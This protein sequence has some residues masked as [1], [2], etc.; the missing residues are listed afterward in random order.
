MAGVTILGV[1]FQRSIE[2]RAGPCDLSAI[3]VNQAQVIMHVVQIWVNLQRFLERSNG[4]ILGRLRGKL[5]AP[6]VGRA[7]I[8]PDHGVVWFQLRRML[9]DRG[10]LAILALHDVSAAQVDGDR[11]IVGRKLQRLLQRNQGLARALTG[12]KPRALVEQVNHAC[13][14]IRR[15]SGR[16]F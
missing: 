16:A 4:L 3:L 2:M 15:I 12:Q 7:Q 11:D 5:Q 9:Q 6:Q 13:G 1:N 14:R 10:C 8:R